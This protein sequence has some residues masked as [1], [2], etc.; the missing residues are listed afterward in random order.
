[1]T[2]DSMS[3]KRV[4]VTGASGTLGAATARRLAATGAH[5]GVH[6]RG[7]AEAADALV[8]AIEAD[9]G[10]AFAL[11]AD[12]LEAAE[13]DGLVAR[14]IE[15]LGGLDALVNTAG[16]IAR[17]AHALAL[18]ESAWDESFAL[19]AKAPFFLARDA[20][21]HMQA[22]GGGRIVNVSSIGVKFGGSPTS[23]H[24]SA[25]K[26]A[27]EGVTLGLAKLGAERGVLV[28]A[29]RAGVIDTP[30]H[31]SRGPD[32]MERRRQQI[33]MKRLGTPDEVARMIAFLIGPG[34]DFITGQVF[35]VSG[36]E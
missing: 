24:Y 1:M 12:L 17:P 4:L 20:F 27:L 25:A 3:G 7:N 15:G 32:A 19:N 33:P 18:D 35:A 22:N 16:A 2:T 6:Y 21:L 23:L 11:R 30:M 8:R 13:R 9:G 14:A 31:G 34:G 28:N 5:V 36:G 29:V 26:R 10:R